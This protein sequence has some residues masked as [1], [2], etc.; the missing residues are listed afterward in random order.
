M[1]DIQKQARAYQ[2][3][4]TAAREIGHIPEILDG[5]THLSALMIQTGKTDAAANTLAYVLRHPDVPFD[6]YDRAEDMFIALE[7]ALCPRVIEDARTLATY[8]TLR[9]AVDLAY[10]ALA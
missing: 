5:L 7:A 6:V 4:I 3:A 1:N 10:E 8:Q 9:G 2:V